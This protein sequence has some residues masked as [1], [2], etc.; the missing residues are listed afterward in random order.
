MEVNKVEKKTLC[1]PD[2][3]NGR[4]SNSNNL[5]KKSLKSCMELIACWLDAAANITTPFIPSSLQGNSG[6]N[7]GLIHIVLF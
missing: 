5:V 1:E 2:G 4:L 3:E 7:M 6:W